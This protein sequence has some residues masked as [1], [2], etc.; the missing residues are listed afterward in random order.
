MSSSIY[1]ILT[2]RPR[3]FKITL[4]LCIIGGDQNAKTGLGRKEFPDIVGRYGKREMN[5]NGRELCE[6]LLRNEMILCNTMFPHK[7][8]HHTTWET[9]IKKTELKNNTARKNP[10]INQLTMW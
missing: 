6:M 2:N 4:F 9:S 5:E 3:C 10:Y 1:V 8:A 7:M